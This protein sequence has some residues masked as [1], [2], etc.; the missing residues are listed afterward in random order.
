MLKLF[1]LILLFVPSTVLATTFWEDEM[2][3]GTPF[4]SSSNFLTNLSQTV[5]GRPPVMEIDTT[6]KHSGTGSFRLNYYSNCQNSIPQGQCGGAAARQYTTP[7]SAAYH[8]AWLRISGDTNQGATIGS[9]GGAFQTYQHAY[10][11]LFEN[12]GTGATTPPRSWLIFGNASI[13]AK[14]MSVSAE[15]AGDGGGVQTVPV[16]FSIPDNTWVCI[17]TFQ[18]MNSASATPDGI[19]RVWINEVLSG[20]RTD[21]RW[22]TA[23]GSQWTEFE[24][25]RQGGYGNMWW[26]QLAAGDTRIGCGSTP[27]QDITNPNP[28]TGLTA[29]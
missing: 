14:N 16:A 29:Q 4:A 9:A 5:S 8:R 11:K 1:L 2:E 18:Q 22:R 21:I 28:P 27:P 15:N 3:T 19:F 17:E 25:F 7:T 6:I 23:T 13:T 26:D 10:T 20:E 12:V 24:I